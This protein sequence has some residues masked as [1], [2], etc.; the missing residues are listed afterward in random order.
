MTLA[1][2]GCNFSLFFFFFW[3]GG[4]GGRVGGE[5]TQLDMPED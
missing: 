2:G 1:S 4:G 5:V 3:L